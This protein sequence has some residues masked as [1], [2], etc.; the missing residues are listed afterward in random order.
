MCGAPS[1]V[2]DM[3]SGLYL[4]RFH[5][6]I[7]RRGLSIANRAGRVKDQGFSAGEGS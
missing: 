7:S 4:P 1:I 3:G 2:P 5:A 6:C